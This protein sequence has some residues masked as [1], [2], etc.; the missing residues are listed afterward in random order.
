MDVSPLYYQDD[1]QIKIEF[2]ARL[3]ED[4]SN[5][6][7]G[8]DNIRLTAKFDCRRRKLRGNGDMDDFAEDEVAIVGG[9]SEEP[10]YFMEDAMD[11]F[12]ADSANY[13]RG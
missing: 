11:T 6:S 8:Y 5:E 12:E 10:Q 9:D 1:G 13:L 3:N 7:A 2:Q 4:I